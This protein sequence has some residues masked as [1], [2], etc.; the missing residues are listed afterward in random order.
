MAPH[1]EESSTEA[2]GWSTGQSTMADVIREEPLNTKGKIDIACIGAGV[3]G[4]AAAMQV[5]QFMSNCDFDIY[6]KNGDLG[7]TWLENR[8]PGCACRSSLMPRSYSERLH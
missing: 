4:L 8:Y 1:A 6:E 7:G 2:N 3:S 5:Q